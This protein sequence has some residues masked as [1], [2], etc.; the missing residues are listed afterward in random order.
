MNTFYCKIRPNSFGKQNQL[1]E[2]ILVL[3]LHISDGQFMASKISSWVE[4]FAKI[5]VEQKNLS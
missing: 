2:I 5:S 3:Y 4:T 1:M